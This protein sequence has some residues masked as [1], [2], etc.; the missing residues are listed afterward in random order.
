MNN[1]PFS[2][3]PSPL[4]TGLK[5]HLAV[6]EE[7]LLLAERENQALRGPGD[8]PA[9]EFAQR[10]KTLLPRLTQS[11]ECLSRNRAAWQRLSTT[12]RARY[13]EAGA[14]LRANQDLIM[15][16]IVLDRE[17]EQAL[18][19]RGLVPPRHLPPADR[20]RPH[21]VAGLYQRT[22]PA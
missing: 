12:E 18:L 1:A 8:Y 15:R 17:N 20:Q 22:G 16:I 21:V 9:D 3:E 14:L 6:C 7:V 13:A 5:S 4:V 19:R 2:G 11:L 10:R